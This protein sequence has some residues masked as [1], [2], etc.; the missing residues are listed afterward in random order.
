MDVFGMYSDSMKADSVCKS[1][2]FEYS[3]YDNFSILKNYE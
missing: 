1:W 3:G 2:I